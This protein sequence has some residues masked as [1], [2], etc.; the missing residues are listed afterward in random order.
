MRRDDNVKNAARSE[1]ATT[2]RETAGASAGSA[3]AGSQLPTPDEIMADIIEYA[4]AVARDDFETRERVHDSIRHGHLARLY[5]AAAGQHRAEDDLEV[6]LGSRPTH[7]CAG[8]DCANCLE[9]DNAI[10]DLIARRPTAG[11]AHDSKEPK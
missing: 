9:R 4:I 11:L 2:P 10:R 3:P 5:V 8:W 6:I 1:G 7:Q